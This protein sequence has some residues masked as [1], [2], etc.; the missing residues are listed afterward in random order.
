MVIPYEIKVL[1]SHT[2]RLWQI[3]INLRG[4]T[5]YLGGGKFVSTVECDPND[6]GW[7]Y[8]IMKH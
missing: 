2:H 4:G 6:P 7:L 5:L 8:V 3:R 1:L